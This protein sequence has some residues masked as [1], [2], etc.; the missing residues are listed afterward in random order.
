MLR[1][2]RAWDMYPKCQGIRLWWQFPG[3]SHSYRQLHLERMQLILPM[4]Q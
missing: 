3:M 4:H 1:S 2:E